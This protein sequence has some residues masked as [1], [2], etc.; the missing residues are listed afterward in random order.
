MYA[1]MCKNSS[2]TTEPICIKIIPANRA[3][4]AD[5]C[6]LLRFEILTPTI[7][8]TPKTHFWGPRNAKPMANRGLHISGSNWVRKLKC[9]TWIDMIRSFNS[10]EFFSARWRMRTTATPSWILDPPPHISGSNWERKPK[11]GMWIDMHRI[12]NID[13]ICLR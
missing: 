5:C 6:R 12:F 3:S 10:V 13:G 2:K 9:G 4:Y 7:F 11:F 8:K 1:C